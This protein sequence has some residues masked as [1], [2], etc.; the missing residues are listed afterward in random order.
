MGL[1][2]GRVDGG[3]NDGPHDVRLRVCG[4]YRDN[5]RA[6]VRQ[7][8]RI[9]VDLAEIPR[10]DRLRVE[11]FFDMRGAGRLDH[12]FIARRAELAR[13]REHRCVREQDGERE[14]ACNQA[15]Q[16]AA[17][18]HDQSGC[19]TGVRIERG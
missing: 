16:G 9:A 1:G 17:G 18:H 11:R 3:A 14:E 10:I 6:D 7:R 15:A 12:G 4:R 2:R 5:G 19:G 8:R 13:I